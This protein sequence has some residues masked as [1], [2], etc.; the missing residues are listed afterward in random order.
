MALREGDQQQAYYRAA[1][2]WA[3]QL[4]CNALSCKGTQCDIWLSLLDQLID[5]LT[6]WV[7]DIG[8]LV[9]ARLTDWRTKT[10]LTQ[11]VLAAVPTS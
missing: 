9:I 7:N 4:A 2:S 6:D 8:V 11:T 1:C 10:I 3:P 5:R